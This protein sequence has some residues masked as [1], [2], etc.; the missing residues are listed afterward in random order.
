MPPLATLCGSTG[1]GHRAEMTLAQLLADESLRQRE[2]PVVADKVFLSHAAVSPLP[3]RV[4][5]AIGE[6]L[7]TSTKGDQESP[8][9][10]HALSAC[11]ELG[12][13]LL[14]CTPGEIALVGPTSLALS[15]V[16]FGL[17]W[18]PGD[19]VVMYFDDYPSN[20]VPW[21]ALADK[22]VE[23][24]RIEATAL[25]L[26]QPEDVLSQ[27]DKRTRLV[28]I[29][30]CHFL[31]GLR[32]DIGAIG[33]ALRER[34]V[35]LCVDGIQTAGAFHTPLEHVDFFA[36]D[37]HKWLLGPCA[38]GLLYVRRDVQ[39]QLQPIALG[40]H[41]VR[42]PNFVA[43]EQIS[44]RQDAQRYEAGTHNL[45][46]NVG[47]KV[48]LELLLEIGIEPI[49]AELL[50]K[51]VWLVKQLK[52]RDWEVL[53]P[54]ADTRSASGIVSFRKPN[55]DLTLVHARLAERGIVTSLRG[56]RSGTK[57][58]RLSPHFYNTDAELERFVAALT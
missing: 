4:A 1:S 23:V 2:F 20:V 41:N 43:Q 15:F 22:G 48:A 30:S 29:A 54:E 3:A 26:I 51:R 39:D 57:H 14:G 21:Q 52:E 32:P 10:P 18:E 5:D 11:R 53:H 28:S 9:Y 27:V 24:R 49:S 25:G 12:A 45:L 19:N 40:W 37:A 56:D 36:A 17:A 47:L 42:C 34:G 31:A 35:L 50:R 55:V 44:L 33:Q 38:A 58:I 13:K 16:A 7:D 6:C 8:F 46:G